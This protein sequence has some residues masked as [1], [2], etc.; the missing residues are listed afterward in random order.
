MTIT[1]LSKQEAARVQLEKALELHALGGNQVAVITLAGAAEEILGQLV[2]E[3]GGENSLASLTSGA[4]AMH[5]Y[6]HN[7]EVDAKRYIE[8][9][10]RAK[11]SLKHYTPGKE[12]DVSCDFDEEAVDLL[13]RAISNWWALTHSVSP[14]M[15]KFVDG[16]RS[17]SPS[18]TVASGAR[19]RVVGQGQQDKV[20]RVVYQWVALVL[21]AFGVVF[22]VVGQ[23]SA[24]PDAIAW[25]QWALLCLVLAFLTGINWSTAAERDMSDP[26]A[27]PLSRR[28]LGVARVYRIILGI[29]GGITDIVGGTIAIVVVIA[30]ALAALFLVVRV[31]K[32]IWYAA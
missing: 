21:L 8:R 5:K 7:E 29:T 17:E 12:Q 2:R 18:S 20:R 6:L 23:M 3:R 31:L 24:Q 13:D 28:E 26:T 32:A 27:L 11:N 15:R 22:L 10:N 30:L 16:Q 4:V 9:A 14:A 19:E 25:A 1:T